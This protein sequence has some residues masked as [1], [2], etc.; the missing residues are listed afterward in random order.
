M[1]VRARQAE[2]EGV[3]DVQKNE[4]EKKQ[5][6]ICLLTQYSAKVI[7]RLRHLEILNTV[8]TPRRLMELGVQAA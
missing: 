8:T 1:C 3:G 6:L 5:G 2:E 4:D 7:L